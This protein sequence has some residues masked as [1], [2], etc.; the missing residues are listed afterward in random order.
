MTTRSCLEPR[1]LRR[2]L[3]MLLLAL[4]AWLPALARAD[5]DAQFKAA[6]LALK[7]GR[8]ADALK[9]AEDGYVERKQARF[10]FVKALALEKLGRVADAW[11][12]I[13]VV[14]PRDIPAALHTEFA[15]AYERIETAAKLAAVKTAQQ[16]AERAAH[17]EAEKRKTVAAEHDRR[18]HARTARTL[19]LA[20]VGC[21]VLGGGALGYGWFTAD[22]AAT[23]H[24]LVNPSE[25]QAYKDQMA[26]GR[27]LYWSGT[28]VAGLGAILGAL[29]VWQSGK[30]SASPTAT[31]GSDWRLV[32]LGA[33]GV[34]V[35][36]G[37]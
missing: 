3:C 9:S 32:P 16:A 1:V 17:D 6:I 31:A 8:A 20:A 26:L 25:H 7:E 18:A 36:G 21:A 11:Q 13:Q 27:T 35:Q 28:G 12:I 4:V 22:A 10:L 30:A 5:G 34:A 29:A 37:F 23:D 24:N 19:T 33:T 14:M 15:K 2:L